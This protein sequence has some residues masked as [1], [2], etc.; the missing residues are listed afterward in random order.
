MTGS[1]SLSLLQVDSLS[2]LLIFF[3]LGLKFAV[4]YYKLILVVIEAEIT[5]RT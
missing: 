5:T 1:A 2:Y 4:I 3:F